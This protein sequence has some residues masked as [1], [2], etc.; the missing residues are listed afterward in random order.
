MRSLAFHSESEMT[1]P[2][3]RWMRSRGLQVKPEFTLPWGVCDL[4]GVEFDA[5]RV[6]RRLSYG[7]VNSI[8]SDI[9]IAILVLIPEVDTGRS[10]SLHSLASRLSYLSSERLQRELKA[11]EMGRFVTR[12]RFGLFQKRNGWAPLQKR[13]VAVELKLNRVSEAIAQAESNTAFA[14]H[15]FVALPG[16]FAS[17][18]VSVRGSEFRSSGIGVLGVWRSR[19]KEILAAGLANSTYN[20]AVQ[21]HVVERFWRTRDS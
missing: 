6:R 17:R 5:D 11:L 19:C 13:I 9:R 1:D 2:V 20:N 16:H 15:S 18:V 3:S 10:V 12:T 7:Q 14:T 21:A 4:V 8:G